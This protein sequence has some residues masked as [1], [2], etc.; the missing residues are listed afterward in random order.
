MSCY[1]LTYHAS[2]KPFPSDLTFAD[3]VILAGFYIGSFR[4][5]KRE[6]V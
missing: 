6:I 3:S 4:V 5:V 1:S 2:D